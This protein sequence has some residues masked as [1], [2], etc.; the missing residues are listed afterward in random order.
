MRKKIK[1]PKSKHEYGY[2]KREVLDI[3]RPLGI[4]YKTF[5]KKFGVNTCAMHPETGET[6]MY[7]CDIVTAI[8]CCW[9]K[10]DKYFYEWD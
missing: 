9:E 2:T 6:L 5:W 4:H 1:L 8:L 7:G 3:I 10:R